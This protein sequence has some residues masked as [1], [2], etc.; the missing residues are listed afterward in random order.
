MFNILNNLVEYL[1]TGLLSPDFEVRTVL[2]FTGEAEISC[3]E[4]RAHCYESAERVVEF[5]LTDVMER[6][7]GNPLRREFNGHSLFNP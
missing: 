5:R 3:D 6:P 2:Q 7:E 4:E 1:N